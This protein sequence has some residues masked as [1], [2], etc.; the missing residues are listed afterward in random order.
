MNIKCWFCR[1]DVSSLVIRDIIIM[2]IFSWIICIWFSNFWCRIGDTINISRFWKLT[3]FWGPSE[4]FRPKRHRRLS[5]LFKQQ[6][7]L[8]TFWAFDR[9]FS[10]NIKEVTTISIFD[11]LFDLWPSHLIFDRPPNIITETRCICGWILVKICSSVCELYVKYAN[12]I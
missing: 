1:H 5:I 8:P 6:R 11:L 12:L 2:R 9:R 3:K 7:E 10:L 4:P